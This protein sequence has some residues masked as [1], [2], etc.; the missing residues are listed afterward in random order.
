MEEPL[1]VNVDKAVVSGSTEVSR[2][3]RRRTV[4]FAAANVTAR[5][6]EFLI[7]DRN[8]AETPQTGNR[9]FVSESS[10][11]PPER[12]IKLCGKCNFLK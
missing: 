5:L 4:T 11:K 7:H 8:D 9:E 10:C 3:S 6:G 1:S 12:R 2:S